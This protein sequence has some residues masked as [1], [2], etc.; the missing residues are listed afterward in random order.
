M[1]IRLLHKETVGSDQ[2]SVRIR[3]LAWLYSDSALLILSS[4]SQCPTGPFFCS[5]WREGIGNLRSLHVLSPSLS[6]NQSVS[7]ILNSKLDKLQE[8]VMSLKEL[9]LKEL[10]HAN[11][12][13]DLIENSFSQK[14]CA[15]VRSH[16]IM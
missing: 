12:R 4:H 2:S 11:H 6:L 9:F 3:G 15:C 14:N 8:T 5:T 16:S 1:E 13:L 10:N 7:D